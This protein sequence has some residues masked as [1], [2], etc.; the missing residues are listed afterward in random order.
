V[1]SSGWKWNPLTP[2]N[3]LVIGGMVVVGFLAASWL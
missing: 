2:S 3:L 1:I